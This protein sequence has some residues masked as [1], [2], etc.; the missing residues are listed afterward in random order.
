M[1]HIKYQQR[2]LDD[3][4]GSFTPLVFGTNGGMDGE[5][6]T[7]LRQLRDK[8]AK[9]NDVSYPS[10]I[11]CLRA[12]FSFEILKFVHLSVWVL[13]HL[14]IGGTK[15]WKILTLFRLVFF[16]SFSAWGGE[17]PPLYKSE[18]IDAIVMKLE[19]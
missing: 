15:Y 19:G 12:Q 6:Q 13:E 5:C 10:V 8:L 2:V 14:F 18:S 11:T 9:K 4:M 7:I 1:R 16:G 17:S 3:E